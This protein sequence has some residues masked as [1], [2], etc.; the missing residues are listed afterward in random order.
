MKPS[1]Q[2]RESA[3]KWSSFTRIKKLWIKVSAI[4]LPILILIELIL[5]VPFNVKL[6]VILFTL[7]FF[8]ILI[9]LAFGIMSA[10]VK[11][12]S[13]GVETYEPVLENRVDFHTLCQ[14]AVNYSTI[15]LPSIYIQ[16]DTLII[17]RRLLQK[18]DRYICK[19][20]Y[21]YAS[22]YNSSDTVMP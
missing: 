16:I 18:C 4:V 12:I 9:G 21:K 11:G 15:E 22:R 3:L 7:V 5:P 8:G 2:K 19:R 17:N 14:E 13:K 1:L 10:I 6:L 20:I